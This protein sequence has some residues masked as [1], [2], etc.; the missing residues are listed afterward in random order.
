MN[1]GLLPLPF[2]C[3]WI[4]AAGCG[5]GLGYR[6]P[7]GV[8]TVAVPIFQNGTFPLRRDIE[9]E[10]T[11]ALRKEILA[12][13]S[14]RLVDSG[15]ADLVLLGTIR[16]YRTPTAAEGPRDSRIEASL[17]VVVGLVVEDYSSGRRSDVEIRV[18]EPYSPQLGETDLDARDRAVRSLAERMLLAIESWEEG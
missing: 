5:Y 6:A 11:D 18:A 14:L 7:P 10:V 8:E 15:E 13:T 3:T 12:R 9:Y 17:V 4:L 2:L 16:E 1:R